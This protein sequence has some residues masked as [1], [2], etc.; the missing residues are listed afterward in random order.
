M[1]FKIISETYNSLAALYAN[2]GKWVTG[3]IK[4][5]NVYTVG[6]GTSVPFTVSGDAITIGSGEW[7][8]HGFVTGDTI[9]IT[10][11]S[12]VVPI[13]A[14]SFTRTITY[15]NGNIMYID[16]VLTAPFSAKTYPTTGQVGGMTIKADKL[17]QQIDFNFNLVQNGTTSDQSLIDGEVNRF[18][19][20]DAA[21]LVVGGAATLMTQQGFKSGGIIKDVTI[22]RTANTGTGSIEK[23]FTIG[24]KFMQWGLWQP[25]VA[26]PAWYS[27]INHLNPFITGK[28]YPLIGNSNGLMQDNNGA[29]EANTGYF[30]ENYNG[31][32]NLYSL[33]SLSLVDSSSN[34]I[35]QIDYTGT[36][37][38]TAVISAPGQLNGTSKYRIGLFFEPQ[39]DTLFKNKST[40]LENNILVNAPDQDFLH[41]AVVDPTTYTG[42]TNSDG[43]GFNFSNLKFSR[44]ANVLTVTGDIAPTGASEAFF[45]ALGD[46]ERKLRIY[47]QLS[48]HLLTGTANNEVNLTIYNDDCFDA[49]TIGVQFPDIVTEVLKDHGGQDITAS[50]VA[51][52][53]TEDD[54]L[55]TCKFKLKTNLVYDGVRVGISARNT[56]TGESFILEDQF[57][58]FDG[59]D[60]IS[61]KHIPNVTIPRGFALPPDSDRN[62]IKLTRD[63]STDSGAKYGLQLEYGFMNNWRYWFEQPNVDDDFFDTTQSFNG[64]NQNWQRFY[65]GNWLLS[66]DLYVRLDDVDNYNHFTYKV[67]PYEDDP[68]VSMTAVITSP[69]G[70]TPTNFIKNAVSEYDVTF[71]WNASFAEEWAQLTIENY[72]GARLGIISSVINHGGIATNPF[73]PIPGQTKLLLTNGGTSLLAQCLVDTSL[74]GDQN[75][76]ITHRVFS[77]P[78]ERL[79]YLIDRKKDAILGYSLQKISSEF[80]Y[81]GPC[82]RVRRD[83]DDTEM[84]IG[85]DGSFIDT[86]ALIAFTGAGNAYVTIWYDQSF[87]GNHATQ[88]VNSKQPLIVS[89]GTLYADPDNGLPSVYF[90]GVD[91]FFDLTVDFN[92]TPGL[93]QAAVFNRAFGVVTLGNSTDNGTTG[94]W[95]DPGTD[96]IITYIDASAENHGVNATSGTVLLTTKHVAT[97]DTSVY[98]NGVLFNTVSE[99]INA[100]TINQFGKLGAFL[101][102]GSFQ[103]L[104]YWN[105]DK[106]VQ[107]TV[108]HL[109]IMGRYGL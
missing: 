20:T 42:A 39:D 28:S 41:S 79:G 12:Q 97:D 4:V 26:I 66:V 40:S 76:S 23:N 33:T 59:V 11:L 43:A 74:I 37:S 21:N 24:F 99:G 65:D 92:F 102:K 7:Y 38:F 109:N 77:I 53:T 13:G 96:T 3:E 32:A 5:R 84:D 87:A 8:Q 25:N 57:I 81:S 78:K 104:V 49:P 75:F 52:T 107:Q 82:V 17:P 69:D 46:G 10:F 58:S 54:L 89:S 88:T 72:E 80:V 51:N 47:V 90:D 62:A 61:G 91:D 70:S 83:S 29:K 63:T 22:K 36:T 55:Y 100:N 2:A 35:S 30:D 105:T 6:S 60:Y 101:N 85:F 48:N 64:R 50:V 44:A 27:Q 73:K 93:F 95:V 9:T 15:I 56:V 31:G 67:R 45:S 94:I 103:E 16:S 108:I 14:Q 106:S 1:A 71:N 34:V 18:A 98:V 86:D 68:N 19:Y